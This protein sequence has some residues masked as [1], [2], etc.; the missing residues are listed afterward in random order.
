MFVGKRSIATTT[1]FEIQQIVISIFS[2]AINV[3]QLFQVMLLVNQFFITRWR[4]QQIK[5]VEL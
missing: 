5:P 3:T 4:T 1:S 2:S